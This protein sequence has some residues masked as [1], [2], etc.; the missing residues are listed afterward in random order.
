MSSFRVLIVGGSIT[1]LS[2]AL[3]LEKNNIDFLVLEA[4][5]D[6][7]PQVGASL[8]LQSIGL[9]ILDQLGVCDELL[10]HAQGHTVQESIYRSPNGEKMWRASN[11]SDEMSDRHGYPIAFLDRQTVLQ[12]LYNKVQNKSKILTGKRVQTIDNS[13]PTMVNVITTDGSIYSGDI[14]VGAD[15]IH[16]TVRQEMARQDVDTGRDYLEEK[17]ISATYSCVFGISH[18]TPGIDPGTLQDVFNEKFSYLIAD[19][20]GDRTY[21]FLFEHMDRVRFGQEIPRLTE[22]DR[23]EM[24]G[25][26]FDDP[27]TSDVKFG[28][29]Y[30]RRIRSGVTPLQEH[31]YKHWHYGR[32]IAL[33]DASHKLHP[34]TG[35]G[36]NCCIETAACLTNGLMRL[37]RSTPPGKQVPDREISD[38]FETV[39]RTRQ[40]RVRQ[41]IEIAHKRQKLEAMD[42]PELKSYVATRIPSLPVKVV[43]NEWLKTIPQAVS[44]D[45][46]P[47]PTRPHRVPYHDELKAEETKHAR[48]G[49]K[50]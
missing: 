44:L 28:D 12:T 40:P 35:L 14:V 38:M 5:L 39:E 10:E 8:A 9:R 42:T 47:L 24:A 22:A 49:S 27:I 43:Y 26:H 33:G 6:I 11:L 15:G 2:L 48:E 29:I 7:A 13:D 46:L 31:V 36:A 3:M 1:G 50:L 23:D 41:L 4:Y 37:L 16:S 20:P 30:A 17:S 25:R 34:L 21:F 32:M 45:M 19:G 18:R